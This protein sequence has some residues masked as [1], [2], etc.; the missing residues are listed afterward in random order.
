MNKRKHRIRF[1]SYPDWKVF[2]DVLKALG[3]KGAKLDRAMSRACEFHKQN[4]TEREDRDVPF[5]DLSFEI[6]PVEILALKAVCRRAKIA[7]PEVCDPLLVKPFLSPPETPP[8]YAGDDLLVKAIQLVKKKI[9]KFSV[10]HWKPKKG[11]YLV[12]RLPR[13]PAIKAALDEA[14]ATSHAC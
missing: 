2:R 11:P 7:F 6:F 4:C 3:N 5:S 14:A 8:C 1:P 12:P 10:P 13:A 9:P